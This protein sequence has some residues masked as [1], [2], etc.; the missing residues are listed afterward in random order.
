[1]SS[2]CRTL[3]IS[4][5]SRVDQRHG[6]PGAHNLGIRSSHSGQQLCPRP[7][8]PV[9]VLDHVLRLDR[10]P[11]LDLVLVP[12]L[13]LLST[14]HQV[15]FFSMNSHRAWNT[16]L[17]VFGRMRHSFDLTLETATVR[18]SYACLC[19]CG[20]RGKEQLSQASLPGRRRRPLAPSRLR[21]WR[22]GC[23]MKRKCQ[24]PAAPYPR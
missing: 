8:C 3:G 4:W 22:P 20:H 17:Y 18:I 2:P 9:R 7:F 5:H 1:M 10:F 21:R 12:S 13:T 19:V 16:M 24:S 15:G 23:H 6:G 11:R 14:T